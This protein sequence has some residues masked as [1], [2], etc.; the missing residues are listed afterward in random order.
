[1]R[2]NLNCVPS[3]RKPRARQP[4]KRTVDSE[5]RSRISKLENLVES[6]SGEAVASKSS[7]EEPH[8]IPGELDDASS[9]T[10]GKY[11]GLVITVMY[12]SMTNFVS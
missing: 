11:V 12:E 2:S 4:G 5:L 6:L 10:V 8:D 9:P 1:M 7:L 3:Q